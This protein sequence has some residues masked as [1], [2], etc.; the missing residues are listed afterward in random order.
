MVHVVSII[1]YWLTF[2]IGPQ[3]EIS[4]HRLVSCKL[5]LLEALDR[6]QEMITGSLTEQSISSCA[7]P[8]LHKRDE[9][10]GTRYCQFPSGNVDVRWVRCDGCEKWL[11]CHC[12]GVPQ[13]DDV[14]GAWFCGCQRRPNMRYAQS[15]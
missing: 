12:A 4:E 9:A 5:L 1:Y 14:K 13:T 8:K 7:G 15:F 3:G 11:H 2:F 6:P 10:C